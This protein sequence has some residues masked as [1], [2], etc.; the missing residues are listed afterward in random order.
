MAYAFNQMTPKD[1]DA[2]ERWSDEQIEKAKGR[3]AREFL[4]RARNMSPEEF[5]EAFP[6]WA[7]NS[8]L[9]VDSGPRFVHSVGFEILRD[10][11]GLGT[12]Y[13][14]GLRRYTA[15]QLAEVYGTGTTGAA[16]G[17]RPR[18]RAAWNIATHPRPPSWQFWRSRGPEITIACSVGASQCVYG[19]R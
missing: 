12:D 9:S 18:T 3:A 7:M 5:K 8:L 11:A 13:I 10:H 4:S 15:E 19:V 1:D 17:G 14:A 6:D 2:R 16:L